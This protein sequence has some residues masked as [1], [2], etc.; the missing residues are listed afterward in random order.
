MRAWQEVDDALTAFAQAQKRRVA[1]G[2]AA[3]QD[4]IA[5]DAAKQRYREGLVDF[6]NVN[7]S[8]HA[9]PEPDNELVQSE[10]DVASRSSST[11]R[12]ADGGDHQE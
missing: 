7:K 5:L 8:L 1:A 11:A 9:V 10:V 6:L 12:S 2:R 4:K 3:A